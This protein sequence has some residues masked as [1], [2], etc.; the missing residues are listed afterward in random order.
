MRGA[1]LGVSEPWS[2]PTTN[3]ARYFLLS[4]Y[5]G[6]HFVVQPGLLDWGHLLRIMRPQ[7][8]RPESASHLDVYLAAIVPCDSMART[9]VQ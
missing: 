7:H 1:E 2:E 6:M 3:V 9:N 4:W 5:A 8:V